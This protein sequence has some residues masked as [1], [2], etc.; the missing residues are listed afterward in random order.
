M[1]EKL[2][3]FLI[4]HQGTITNYNIYINVLLIFSPQLVNLL[5]NSKN[6]EGFVSM[7]L[8]SYQ[9]LMTLENLERETL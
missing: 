4:L 2:E 6:Q 1:S 8:Q 5:Q 3:N 7:R 9:A